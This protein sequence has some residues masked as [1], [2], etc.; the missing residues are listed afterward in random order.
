MI[1]K[2]ELYLPPEMRER[3]LLCNDGFLVLSTEQSTFENY[4]YEDLDTE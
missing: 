2:K 1:M 4:Y 3:P